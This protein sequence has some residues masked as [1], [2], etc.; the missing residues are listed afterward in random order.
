MKQV[1]DQPAKDHSNRH[2]CRTRR[3]DFGCPPDSA[4]RRQAGHAGSDRIGL[5]Q[6]QIN[7]ARNAVLESLAI[8]GAQAWIQL[9]PPSDGPALFAEAQKPAARM[10]IRLPLF[11]R[12]LSSTVR[13]LTDSRSS[14]RRKTFSSSSWASQ[15]S[16]L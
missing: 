9:E 7:A 13:P 15:L 14:W 11:S 10:T 1:E 8:L 6:H 16:W 5:A 12:G 4:D 2:G 3:R